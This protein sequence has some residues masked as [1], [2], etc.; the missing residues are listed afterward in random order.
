MRYYNA[1]LNDVLADVDECANNETHSCTDTQLCINTPGTF[2][3]VCVTGYRMTDGTCQGTRYS[4][5]SRL[6][7][8]LI[9]Y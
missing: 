7:I 9:I 6:T 4:D 2:T 5:L 1:Q 3:C 8:L